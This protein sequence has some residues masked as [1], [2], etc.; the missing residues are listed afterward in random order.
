V[1]FDARNGLTAISRPDILVRQTGETVTST[2][3]DQ[4]AVCGLLVDGTIASF[5]MRAGSGDPS[6]LW[7]VQGEEASLRITSTGSRSSLSHRLGCLR[8][9]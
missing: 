1:R 2:S 6:F 5:H 4:I 3:P 9:P 7:E 8:R